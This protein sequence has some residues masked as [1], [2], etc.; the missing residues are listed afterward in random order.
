MHKSD[1]QN[2]QVEAIEIKTECDVIAIKVLVQ[3]YKRKCFLQNIFKDY[4]FLTNK[5]FSKT[6]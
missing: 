5:V 4:F 1:S 2:Q 3:Y 6:Y